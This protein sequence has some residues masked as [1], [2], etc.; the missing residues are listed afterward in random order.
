MKA[1]FQVNFLKSM[2]LRGAMVWAL[3][4]DDFNNRCGCEPF[5]LLKTINRGLGRIS[6]AQPDCPRL[7]RR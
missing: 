1:P 4:L 5:H 6:S 7:G 3:D 2:N